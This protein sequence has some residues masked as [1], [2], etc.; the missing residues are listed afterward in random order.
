MNAAEIEWLMDPGAPDLELFLA[1]LA[2]RPTWHASA[3]CRGMGP[4]LFFLTRRDGHG[5]E[6]KAICG[7]CEVR[8]ECLDAAL[9]MTMPAASGPG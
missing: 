9:A 5:T 6:A 1:E 4:D 7:G 2:R 8:S 3:S